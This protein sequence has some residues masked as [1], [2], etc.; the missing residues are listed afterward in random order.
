VS[1]TPENEPDNHIEPEAAKKRTDAQPPPPRR[2][3]RSLAEKLEE[4]AASAR[5]R[6]D[7]L[8]ARESRLVFDLGK[9]RSELGSARSE[10]AKITGASDR[11]LSSHRAP[12]PNGQGPTALS[13]S[14]TRLELAEHESTP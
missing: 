3:P 6:I 5:G 11:T 13:V 2:G 10:L 7:K 8:A 1:N 4:L 12:P 14:E 9:V